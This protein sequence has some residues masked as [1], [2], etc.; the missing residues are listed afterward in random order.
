MLTAV[1]RC[2]PAD[3]AALLEREGRAG[4]EDVL[5]DLA[6]CLS[7]VVRGGDVVARGQDDDLV[8]LLRGI[9]DLR[10]A[11]MV[12]EK[13]SAAGAAVRP[14]CVGVT[15]VQPG[16]GLA[17]VMARAQGALDMAVDIG[18]GRVMS[19]PPLS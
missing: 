13:L 5:R 12:A 16:E 7:D 2:A 9:Q 19:S 10:S 14:V 4:F 3:A 18:P 8:V 11:V 1:A 15:L 6:S 17:S